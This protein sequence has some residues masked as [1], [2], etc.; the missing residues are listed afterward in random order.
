MKQAYLWWL[1]LLFLPNLGIEQQTPLGTLQM[2]DF[3]IGPY[4]IFVA[5][6]IAKDYRQEKLLASQ[7]VPL[8]LVFF[9]W[10]L[11]VTLLLPFRYSYPGTSEL[12]FSLLKLG[13]L[14]LFASAG[15]LTIKAISLNNAWAEFNWSLLLTGL[16][17]GISLLVTRGDFSDAALPSGL[18]ERAYQDNIVSV[19]IVILIVYVLALLLTGYGTQR[20]KV[21]AIAALT[22]MG[23]GALLSNGRGGWVGAL[24]GL[25]YLSFRLRQG[26]SVTLYLIIMAITAVAYFAFPS[27]Q[28]Q[29]E[30]T[31]SPDQA[32]LERYNAGIAGIDDGVRLTI[33]RREGGKIMES[34]VL[35][36]G[37]FHRAGESGLSWWGSHN[38]FAQMFLETG[39][40]G[41]C[42]VL[43]IVWKM[44]R[45]AGSE[46]ARRAEVE[47]PVKTVLV[48]AFIS[49]LSGE[50][51]YGGTV[52][53][54]LLLVYGAVG[55]LPAPQRTALLYHGDT[56]DSPVLNDY[57]LTP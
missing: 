42:L 57:P 33:L 52:L 43:G 30:R 1:P 6:A 9:W 14:A 56:S 16:V 48:T 2:S 15:L 17:V 36:R 13:K 26:R 38:F 19:L 18:I 49:G 10:A 12:T 5:I 28:Q 11:I 47:L 22:I 8:M 50:Y 44:W 32:Y 20:W 21:T 24:V 34:P 4:M 35:G 41:G 53:F 39:L 25:I 46:T 55:R 23:L 7:L 29:I 3:L 54:A 37:F 40:I 27:F 31:F 45:Q 51:F